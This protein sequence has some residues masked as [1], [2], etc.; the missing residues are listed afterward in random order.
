MVTT[1]NHIPLR[2][3]HYS[4]SAQNLLWFMSVRLARFKLCMDIA[5]SLKLHL[6]SGL[7]L[8]TFFH[9]LHH[10]IL[11]SFTLFYS[12]SAFLFTPISQTTGCLVVRLRLWQPWHAFRTLLN[13]IDVA[14]HSCFITISQFRY[15]AGMQQP[16]LLGQLS[17]RQ[18]SHWLSN[19][20][21][22]E[23]SSLCNT[24][25]LIE[26]QPEVWEMKCNL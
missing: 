9:S 8:H 25:L 17:L 4:I 10:T 23:T 15:F 26:T 5:L 1:Q 18:H 11:L 6:V 21:L 7:W 24:T 16:Q 14:S 19:A 22:E 3:V 2:N 12:V 20:E 13:W